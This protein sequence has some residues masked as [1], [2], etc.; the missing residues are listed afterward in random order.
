MRAATKTVLVAAAVGL[1]TPRQAH[2]V[3]LPRVGG[4]PVALDVTETSIVAQRFDSNDPT[5]ANNNGYFSWLNRLNL[6]LS[7]KKWSA[8]L[9]IDSSLYAV[10]PEDRSYPGFFATLQDKRNAIVDGTTRFRDAVYPAKAWIT[11]KSGTF[12][13]TAGDSYV[14]F[15]RGLVLSMRKVDELGLDTTLFGGKLT[16]ES[17]PFLATVIAGVA[18]P[19]RVDEPT[20]RA[21]LLP[22]PLPKDAVYGFNERLGPQPLFGSDRIVGAQIQAGRGL[23]VTLST[24]GVILTKCA[25]YRYNA[26]G[27]VA[28]SFFDAPF[29]TC[30]QSDVDTWLGT[31]PKSQG[32]ILASSQTINA[33][34]SLEV[35][36]LWGH[37]NF[38]VEAAVQKHDPYALNELQDQG[39]AVYGSLTNTGGPIT[40][41]LEVKSYRNFFPL[42]AAINTSRAAAF[43]NVAYS[44]PPTA[45]V[46]TQD[47]MF[48]F[49]NSCV[50]GGRDRLDYRLTDDLLVYGALGYFV[51]RGENGQCDRKGKSTA[52]NP[53]KATDLVV[54]ASVGSQLTFDGAKSI[55][56]L[57]LTYRDDQKES[58]DLYYREY[59]A[60]YTLTKYV[61]GPYSVEITGR[62]R[63]RREENQNIRSG[64]PNGEPWIQGEH[65][66]AVKVAPKWV[67]S[68]GFEYTTFVGLPT[69]YVNGGV[70]YRF[71]SQSNIRAFVGQNRGG[72]KCVSGICRFFPAFSGARIE[73]TLR[74]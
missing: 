70:V 43:A 9:R 11:Y 34:Q 21:L 1:V 59:A 26:D 38:Y 47:S 55:A 20:G 64:S 23:P 10:R 25:P 50:T 16:V 22:K 52:D 24:H 37:G 17:D 19:A 33:G 71:T 5:D 14:Q 65:Y 61:A 66:N 74:F 30:N 35:P 28:D 56:F 6:L 27:T 29:G 39:N 69:Y 15:G 18:N 42:A 73:L 57:T 32:P 7:W 13:A 12:E 53:A 67:F 51:T 72:L 8:G 58:G 62:H 40:N 36:N 41:T 31:L 54:D 3:D 2:A 68:Q 63:W 44:A 60:Q 46:V 45:E 48:G 49:F 4:A